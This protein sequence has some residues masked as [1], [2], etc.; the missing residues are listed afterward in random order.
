MDRIRATRLSKCCI[1][2]F[3]EHT[4]A[5]LEIA[6]DKNQAAPIELSSAT[7]SAAVVGVSGVDVTYRPV[8]ELIAVTDMKNRKP[9][10]AWWMVH[11]P[12]V[13]LLSGRGLFTPQAQATLARENK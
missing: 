1:D 3:E 6:H 5:A 9:L 8:T 2:F 7:E 11:R 4:S 12:L 13:D 10:D